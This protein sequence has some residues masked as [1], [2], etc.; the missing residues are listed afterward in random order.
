MV[1]D[2]AILPL[3]NNKEEGCALARRRL[4]PY[5]SAMPI[6]D[7]LRGGKPKPMPGNV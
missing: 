5:A 4:S 1:Q 2:C 7:T 6:D 3:L